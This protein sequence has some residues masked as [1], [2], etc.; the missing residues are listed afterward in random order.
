MIKGRYQYKKNAPFIPGIEASGIIIDQNCNN[1]DL[2]N[3]KVIVH[4]KKDVL[5]RKWMLFWKIL[6]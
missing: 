6:Y 3:K 1:K 4:Q 5:A 2:L